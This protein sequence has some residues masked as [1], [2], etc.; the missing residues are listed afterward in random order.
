MPLF[1]E[2][3]VK[4]K[5]LAH[6]IGQDLATLSIDELTE[7]VE[8]LRNEILRLEAAIADKRRSHEAASSFFRK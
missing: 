2:E 3:P 6:E 4:K 5:P 1:D 8:V 7:R